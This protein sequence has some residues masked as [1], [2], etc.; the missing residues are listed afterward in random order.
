[1]RLTFKVKL[2]GPFHE[3]DRNN[4]PLNSPNG[5]ALISPAVTDAETKHHLL[6]TYGPETW[7]IQHL[8]PLFTNSRMA[9][10]DGGCFAA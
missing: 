8:G 4:P 3:N 1:V 2:P 9:V 5:R 6:N 10:L 7:K